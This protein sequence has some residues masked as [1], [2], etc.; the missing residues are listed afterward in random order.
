LKVI[1]EQAALATLVIQPLTS[2]RISM[3]QGNDLELQELME[4]A[5]RSDTS[6]F[7]FTDDGLLENGRCQDCHT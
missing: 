1:D 4:K 2:D 6:G 5:N 3:A 7:H